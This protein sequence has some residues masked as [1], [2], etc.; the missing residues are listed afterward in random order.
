M[1]IF[2]KLKGGKKDDGSSVITGSHMEKARGKRFKPNHEEFC[3]DRR[4]NFLQ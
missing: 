2:Q 3:P 1:C 4:K